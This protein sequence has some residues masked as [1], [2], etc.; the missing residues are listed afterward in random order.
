MLTT[1]SKRKL[2]NETRLATLLPYV[3]LTVLMVV[4]RL[5]FVSDAG[6]QYPALYLMTA[7][8]T[9]AKLAVRG[10]VCT[11]MAWIGRNGRIWRM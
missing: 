5:S 9:F 7:G 3:T 1:P 2:V 6:L 8:F 4:W 11:L 10:R